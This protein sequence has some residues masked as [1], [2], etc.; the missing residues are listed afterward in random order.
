MKSRRSSCWPGCCVAAFPRVLDSRIQKEEKFL[1]IQDLPGHHGFRAINLRH[2]VLNREVV[3]KLDCV[4]HHVSQDFFGIVFKGREWRIDHTLSFT[5]RI[6][7]SMN[8]SCSFAL[9]KLRRGAP[10]SKFVKCLREENS[11]SPVMNVI[12]NPR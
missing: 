6:R 7:R 11:P 10:T 4:K 12:L 9:V 3:E 2:T 5:T 8:G 1:K